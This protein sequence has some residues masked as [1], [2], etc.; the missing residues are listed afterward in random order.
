M[1]RDEVARTPASTTLLLL[2]LSC[3]RILDSCQVGVRAV[4]NRVGRVGYLRYQGNALGTRAPHKRDQ[5][6][7]DLVSN[8]SQAMRNIT[9]K[10]IGPR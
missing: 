4:D 7:P 3:D 2:L 5:A 6:N 9:Q 8:K 10:T 1:G